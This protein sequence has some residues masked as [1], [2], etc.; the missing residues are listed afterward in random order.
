MT[1]RRPSG[2][3]ARGNCR[4][5][6]CPQPYRLRNVVRQHPGYRGCQPYGLSLEGDVVGG[7]ER[8]EGVATS[9]VGVRDTEVTSPDG[10]LPEG[11]VVGGV[12]RCEGVATSCVG[13]RVTEVAAL[14]GCC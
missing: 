9:C 1:C 13:V 4:G 6:R 7:V 8:C 2:L 3:R 5:S 10:L 11:D 14:T 12:E